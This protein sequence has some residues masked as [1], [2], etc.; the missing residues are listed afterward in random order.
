MSD[1]I[2]RGTVMAVVRL[3]IGVVAAWLAFAASAATFTVT[4][5]NDGGAGSLRQAITDANL[6]AGP[7][8][9]AFNIAGA[10]VQTITPATP[11]PAITS[12]VTINGYTQPGSSANTNALNAGINAV[13]LIQLSGTTG[14]LQVSPGAD[15][16][17]IRGLVING[18]GDLI[19]VEAS[20]VTIAGNFLGTN[21]TGT[22]AMPTMIGGFGIRHDVPSANN[23]TIG[24]PAAADRNLI[25]GSVQ[26]GVIIDVGFFVSAATGHVIEG[27][28][29]GTDVT[30]TSSLA[31]SAPG[32]VNINNAIVRGNLISGNGG[33]GITT[34][35]GSGQAGPVTIQS[36]LIGTQRDG[37]SPLPNGNFGGI[38]LS[39][40]NGLIGGP[41][42]LANVIAFN[43]A[44]G[45]HVS[46][47]RQGNRITRE[48]DPLEHVSW[49]S[50]ELA[51]LDTAC[52]R[53]G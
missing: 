23:L 53:S 34:S 18:G 13:L 41:G 39:T 22:V 40:D 15:G 47:N 28:Y 43:S 27:N 10:G 6:A 20:N 44:V 33:G 46:N 45:I 3:L 17:I 30:G 9:I 49:H 24:G 5:T 50:A 11:L 52:Q 8:D 4:N 2:E 51:L 26:G 25:S 1:A 31:G 37:T 21:P 32:L 14:R 38:N 12:P 7:D 29:I 36:N 42:A 16:T 35:V 48:L 19:D